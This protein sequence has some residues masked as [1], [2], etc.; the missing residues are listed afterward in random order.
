MKYGLGKCNVH[1]KSE[2]GNTVK[3]LNKDK[4]IK[5]STICLQFYFTQLA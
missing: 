5:N 2:L 1:V 4:I 3:Y